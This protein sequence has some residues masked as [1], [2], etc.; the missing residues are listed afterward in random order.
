MPTGGTARFSSPLN[1][2]DFLKITSV[3]SF[4]PDDVRQLGQAS[5]AVAHAEGLYAHAAAIEVRLDELGGVGAEGAGANG[6]G[7]TG[8]AVADGEEAR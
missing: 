3:F 5:I 6:T 7:G 1:V 8:G 4:G 2:D